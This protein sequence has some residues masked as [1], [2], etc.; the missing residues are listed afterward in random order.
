VLGA[1][2]GGDVR[3][4]RDALGG[5]LVAELFEQFARG[6]DERDAVPLALP[7]QLGVLRQEAVTRVDRVDAVLL[8]DGDDVLDVEVALT[9]SRPRRA[10]QVRLIALKRCS[11]K[12]SS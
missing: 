2:N 7:R 11:E 9:G 6:A 3:L 10:D 8:G 1:G 5:G 12:R 4:G